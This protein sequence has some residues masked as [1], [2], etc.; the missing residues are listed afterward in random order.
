MAT[1]L[2]I[3]DSRLNGIR[4]SNALSGAGHDLITANAGGFDTRVI[5]CSPTRPNSTR[6][7]YE[8]LKFI[9]DHTAAPAVRFG[10]RVLR[11]GH[12]FSM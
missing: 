9:Q 4:I 12:P 6:A 1:I 10:R 8:R 5:L 11:H 2:V 7:V 3:D